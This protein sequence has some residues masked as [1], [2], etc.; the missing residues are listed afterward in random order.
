MK[1]LLVSM[2]VLVFLG[3]MLLWA[4]P[5]PKITI[6]HVPPGNAD[7]A[8]EITISENAWSAHEKHCGTLASGEPLCDSII[9]PGGA[10]PPESDIVPSE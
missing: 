9:E 10:C 2:T 5:E 8:H 4:V 1:A 7:N 6:C 3:T